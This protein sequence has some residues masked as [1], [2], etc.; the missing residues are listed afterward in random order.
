[1]MQ[2]IRFHGR[3]G[4]GT[5]MAS[6]ILAKALF[7]A[8]NYVQTFPVF[9]VERRGAPVEA[10]LRLDSDK[11]L[12]RS[13]VYLADHVIVQDAK[14]LHSIE[15]TKGLK[16][17]GLILINTAAVP[18]DLKPFADFKL[19]VVDA[20]RIAIENELG[21][22]THPIANTAMTGAFAKVF[23]MPPLDILTK[24]IGEEIPIKPQNNIRA[25]QQAYDRVVLQ[26]Y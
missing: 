16:A 14:L 13:N 18:A 10:Y 8:G 21:T 22:R 24:V 6:I 5:V 3:G 2:E 1:M 7:N 23:G 9:G 4:Q 11:I 12:I 26:N 19:A 15:I 25:A 17:G 20:T